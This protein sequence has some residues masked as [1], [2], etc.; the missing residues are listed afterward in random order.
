[1]RK[2]LIIA[3]WK[4]NTTLA[5]ATVLATSVKNAVRNLDIDV[6]LCPP[7]TWLVPLNEILEGGP[8]NLSLGAQNM[9]FAEKGAMTGEISPLMLE[10][11]VKFVILGHSERRLHFQES[12]DLINDKIQAAFQHKITPIVCVGELKKNG[13]R[14]K[15]SRPA[16]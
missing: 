7:F 13:S 15:V 4:M 14:K 8:S 12:D 1:M 2:P 10:S 9:W 11:L 16:R 3:N 5:D 6:V